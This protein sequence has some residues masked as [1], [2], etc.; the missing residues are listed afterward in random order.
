MCKDME[1]PLVGAK[2]PKNRV[3]GGL[4]KGGIYGWEG[5]QQE[6]SVG[7]GGRPRWSDLTGPPSALFS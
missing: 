5:L 4:R 6:E 1:P 2:V 3:G 7:S